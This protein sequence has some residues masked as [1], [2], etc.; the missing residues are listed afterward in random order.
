[1]RFDHFS[2]LAPIY[3]RV[4][5]TPNMDR[6][7]SL[8]ALTPT[9]RLLDLGGGTGRILCHLHNGEAGAWIVDPA[10]GMLREAQGKG[11]GTCQGLA[12]DA[13]FRDGAFTKI[14]AVDSYH[15]M[16]DQDG[17]VRELLR[18]LAPGGRLVV[19]EP[20]IR[21]F[22]VKLIALGEKLALMTSHFRTAEHVAER[23]ATPETSVSVHVGSHMYW[24][25]VDKAMQAG[26]RRNRG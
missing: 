24:V 17:A 1:M 8:V 13:P 15:H 5:R 11:L 18:L 3:D 6:L 22:T 10:L 16:P 26:P 19:E 25:V 4:I 23:F 9:D 21:R 12:E 7:R 20:D 2:F 14:I